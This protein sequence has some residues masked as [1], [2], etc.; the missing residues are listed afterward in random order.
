[1]AMDQLSERLLAEA[2]GETTPELDTA[3]SSTVREGLFQDDT[4]AI[5]T[6]TVMKRD[7]TLKSRLPF[8][9]SWYLLATPLLTASILVLFLATSPG[10]VG[11]FSSV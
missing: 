5:A 4:A 6:H 10:T 1:M 3:V 7:D 11:S 8:K 9:K 2:D